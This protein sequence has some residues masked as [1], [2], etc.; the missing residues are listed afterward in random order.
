MHRNISLRASVKPHALWGSGFGILGFSLSLLA[1]Q[2]T[3][4]ALYSLWKPRMSICL[5]LLRPH[6]PLKELLVL[7]SE[8]KYVLQSAAGQLKEMKAS[9]SSAQMSYY[10]IFL[11]S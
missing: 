1:T 7:F 11:S 9:K 6:R 4:C 2:I 5:P 10:A 8:F 3:S